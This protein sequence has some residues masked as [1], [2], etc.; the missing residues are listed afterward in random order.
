MSHSEGH[1]SQEYPTVLVKK[2]RVKDSPAYF[3]FLFI[4]PIIPLTWVG[5][6]GEGRVNRSITSLTHM[7]CFSP[8]SYGPSLPYFKSC[9]LSEQNSPRHTRG[10]FLLF[11]VIS[12]HLYFDDQ[13]IVAISQK[14]SINR[15]VQTS[16]L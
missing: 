16:P 9:N 5:L 3:A 4:E 12:S 14:S 1:N 11:F 10:G 7:P 13:S 2:C 15:Y 8:S 6:E